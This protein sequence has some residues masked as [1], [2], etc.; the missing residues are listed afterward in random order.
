LSECFHKGRGGSAGPLVRAVDEGKV[1]SG[2]A[3]HGVVGEAKDVV[4]DGESGLPIELDHARNREAIVCSGLLLVIEFRTVEHWKNAP[5]VKVVKCNPSLKHVIIA[6]SF[7]VLQVNRVVD[8]S[9]R[10]QLVAPNNSLRV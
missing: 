3:D 4:V 6:C 10:V 9:K 2:D 7:A 5:F 1:E 8:V